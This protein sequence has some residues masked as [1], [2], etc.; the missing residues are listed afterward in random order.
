VSHARAIRFLIEQERLHGR[1]ARDTRYRGAPG[2]VGSGGRII[3]VKAVGGLLRGYGLLLEPRQVEEA[4]AN[5]NFYVYLVENV[6]QGDR[7]KFELRGLGGDHLRRLLERAREHRYFELATT[8]RGTETT[9][10]GSSFQPSSIAARSRMLPA[11]TTLSR[12]G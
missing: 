5:P 4:R 3:E 12:P 6:A 8:S 9:I 10:A 1:E 2:D 7:A 11:M